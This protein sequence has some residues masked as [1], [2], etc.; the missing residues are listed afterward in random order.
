MIKH[1]KLPFR[2]DTQESGLPKVVDADGDWIAHTAHID[3]ELGYGNAEFFVEACNSHD[4][5]LYIAYAFVG[6]ATFVE[7]MGGRTKQ[8]I[9]W[10][11]K[12]QAIIATAEGG[13]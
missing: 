7:D 4:E 2:V 3:R 1:S 13:K 12:T 9:E 6:L 10:I 8:T 5:L 11:E